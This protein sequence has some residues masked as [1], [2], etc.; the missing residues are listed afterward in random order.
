M[1]QR[2]RLIDLFNFDYQLECYVPAPKRK[3]GYLAL[4]LLYKGKFVGR[5]DYS[6]YRTEKVLEVKGV[7]FEAGHD[8]PEVAV[9]LAKA[10]PLCA[11]SRLRRC[12]KKGPVTKNPQRKRPGI[13]KPAR[14]TPDA[15]AI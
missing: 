3:Y 11:L 9:A 7:F 6:V 5:M 2:K 8:T 10:L 1:I 4:P 13:L 14:S 12:R 15:T